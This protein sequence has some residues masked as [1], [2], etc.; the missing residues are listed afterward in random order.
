MENTQEQKTPEQWFQALKEPY[1]SEAITNIDKT[2]YDYRDFQESL[3]D[4]LMDSFRWNDTKQGYDYWQDVYVSIKRGETTYLEP[5]ILTPEQMESGKW[6][7]VDT[8]L[9]QFE[10]IE[11]D[12]I[13]RY[14]S[15]D[16][17]CKLNFTNIRDGFLIIKNHNKIRPATKEEVLKYFPDEVFELIE[18]RPE[19]LKK[20]EVYTLTVND[21]KTLKYTFCHDTFNKELGRIY[22]S[23]FYGH[24]YG[25]FKLNDYMEHMPGGDNIRLAT[26]EE[27]ASLLRK[28]PTDWEA[29]YNKLQG[30]H[31]NLERQYRELKESYTNSYNELQA[32][33]EKLSAYNDE[34]TERINQTEIKNNQEKVYFYWADRQYYCNV[35]KQ[36][37]IDNSDNLSEVYEA[38]C[39]GKKKSILEREQDPS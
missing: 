9:I 21:D 26:P 16:L 27:S 5:E 1:R 22:Y 11:E 10:K 29:K 34:L 35:E 2:H 12:R 24:K 37:A 25:N 23:S 18:L 15:F 28:K 30:V 38:V 32:K 36:E 3:Y 19:D 4:S 13:Y 7:V 31:Q 39:I 17:E 6:Y 20:G 14:K 8:F 33:Y